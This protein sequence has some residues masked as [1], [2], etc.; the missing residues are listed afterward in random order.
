VTIILNIFQIPIIPKILRFLKSIYISIILE[1]VCK[2]GLLFGA[3]GI[4]NL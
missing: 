4:W 1:Y 3:F 2:N